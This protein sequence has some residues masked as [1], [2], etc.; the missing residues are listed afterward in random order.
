MLH[1]DSDARSR[2]YATR[3]LHQTHVL[4]TLVRGLTDAARLQGGELRLD[5][6]TLDLIPLIA[7]VA[8]T[9]RAL[10]AGHAIRLALG[11]A[12]VWVR[13]DTPSPSVVA[14]PGN[15]PFPRGHRGHRLRLSCGGRPSHP[16]RLNG[17]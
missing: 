10:P 4:V 1:A 14:H 9:V 13:G 15:G 17:G 12:P 3:A 5:R 2:L 11:A 8:E 6:A 16:S 7:Q